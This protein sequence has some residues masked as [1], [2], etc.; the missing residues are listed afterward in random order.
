MTQ[1]VTR[2]APS[3]TGYLHIGGARTALFN[4]LYARHYGGR[5]L[6]RIED[7]DKAR[8]IEEAVRPILDGLAW[9]GIDHDGDAVRQS[10]RSDRHTEVAMRLLETGAAFRCHMTADEVEARKADNRRNGTAFRSD[11]RDRTRGTE[12][13]YAIRLRAPDSGDVVIDDQVQGRVTVKASTLDDMIL[14]R[15]DG[16]PTYMLASVVDD[17]DMG[18][19]HVIRGDDHLSNAFR[20][21]GIIRALG[22]EEPT[23]AHIPLIHDENGKKLSKRHG[24]VGIDFYR[25]GGYTSDAVFNYLLRLGWGHGDHDVLHRDDA[26]RLFDLAEV[27]RAPSRLD[28]KRLLHLNGTH[29]RSMDDDAFAVLLGGFMEVTAA[30]RQVIPLVRERSATLVEAADLI[31]MVLDGPTNPITIDDDLLRAF[32]ERRIGVDPVDTK[33]LV[34][35]IAGEHEVK[36]KV[37]VAPIRM[38]IMGSRISPPLFDAMAIIGE[39]E[40]ARRLAMAL[41]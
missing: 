21:V 31:R 10:E 39:D 27:G 15:S 6:L 28:H 8:N 2:F 22:W 13:T 37:A 30:A 7:T 24:A 29:L 3:P 16:T 36:T 1:I 34:E 18:V 33:S 40:V 32:A 4:W 25:D 26:V 41:S 14:L 38:A 19:T 17:H 35:T 12:G 23:Y 20:Q 11:D 5:F 9:L